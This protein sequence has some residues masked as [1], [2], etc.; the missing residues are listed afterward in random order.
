VDVDKA[1]QRFYRP[2]QYN[3]DDVFLRMIE[4]AL[5]PDMRVLDAGAGAGDLFQYEL[6]EQVKEMVGVDLDPRVESNPRLHRGIKSDLTNIP[7]ED[8]TFDLVFSRYVFE[9]VAE[10]QAFLGEMHRLLK[11]GGS[12]LFLAPNKWHYFSL[13]AQ[14]TPMAFHSWYN[15]KR[16]RDDEDT[17]PTLYKLNS[18]GDLNR[19]MDRAGFDEKQ[20]ILRECSPNYLT[21][22]WPSFLIGVAYERIVNS[23]SMFRR[24][25]VNLLGEYTKR[26]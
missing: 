3:N 11:P 2:D 9:H 24:F 10:P 8:E 22:S 19:E 6:K 20:L 13:V 7:C 26:A 23:W 17:F 16:G 5:R 4:S 21:F 25:R 15:R 18:P 1:K 12:L 14:C